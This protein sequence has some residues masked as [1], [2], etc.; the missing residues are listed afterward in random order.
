MKKENDNLERLKGKNPFSLPDGYMEGLTDRIMSQIPEKARV[1]EE[2]TISLM[3]HIRPWLYLAAIF[4]G[5]GLFFKA[6]MG[7]NPDEEA[8]YADSLFVN[9]TVSH[10]ALESMKDE[11]LEE[12]Q[13][14]LE[15]LETQYADYLLSEEMDTAE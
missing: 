5:L 8:S 11:M 12:E 6:I 1:E 14:Y 3:D 10:E 9:S 4:V 2:K 7:F 15:F 13:E